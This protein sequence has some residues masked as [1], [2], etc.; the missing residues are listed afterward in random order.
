M[1]PVFSFSASHISVSKKMEVQQTTSEIIEVCYCVLWDLILH[2][3][4]AL[5]S[6]TLFTIVTL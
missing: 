1:H 2:L 3:L 4:L 6:H 5:L